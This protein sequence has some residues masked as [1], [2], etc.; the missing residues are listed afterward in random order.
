VHVEPAPL[1]QESQGR[2]HTVMAAC[3]SNSVRSS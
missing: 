2:T 1:P 3:S